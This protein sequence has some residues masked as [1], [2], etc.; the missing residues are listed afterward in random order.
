MLPTYR[1]LGKFR[2][3]EYLQREWGFGGQRKWR[4]G[5]LLLA[6]FFGGVGAGQFLI[7]TLLEKWP[8]SALIGLLIVLIGKGAAH[9]LFLGRPSRFWRIFFRPQTSW[10]SR[11]LIFMVIFVVFGALYL[12][13]DLGFDWL[14]WS[15]TSTT[16]IVLWIVAAF[17][18]LCMM[19]YDGFLL[20]SGRSIPA[21]HNGIIPLLFAIYSL[22]SGIAL[23]STLS[24][25][26]GRIETVAEAAYTDML[27]LLAV[28]ASLGVYLLSM[29]GASPAARLSLRNLLRGG[30]APFFIGGTIIAGVVVPL[31]LIYLASSIL[32]LEVALSLIAVAGI[33]ALLGDLFVRH[34][35]LKV[36]YH[37]SPI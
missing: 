37:T 26:S 36:G 35:I 6:F 18:S 23:T 20:M 10:I 12:A 16:G 24:A 28:L 5:L 1:D 33:L 22:D 17:A 2:A 14:P 29:A 11:G 30:V 15:S 8:L 7:S 27:V 21:W 19:I 25:L 13:P 3:G 9:I 31:I 34:S 4:D 32:Y